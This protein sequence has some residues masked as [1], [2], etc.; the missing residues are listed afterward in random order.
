MDHKQV[1]VQAAQHAWDLV[2]MRMH[3]FPVAR[4][5]VPNLFRVLGLGPK[6]LI[7]HVRVQ[8]HRQVDFA[9]CKIEDL[10]LHLQ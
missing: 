8:R 9:L 4:L 10:C 7:V 3:H 1:L 5:L 2:A 6:I